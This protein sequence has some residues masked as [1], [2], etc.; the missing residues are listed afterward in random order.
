MGE[1][2]P[3]VKPQEARTRFFRDSITVIH[4]GLLERVHRK[5]LEAF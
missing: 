3:Y 1:D 2:V 4:A 5:M